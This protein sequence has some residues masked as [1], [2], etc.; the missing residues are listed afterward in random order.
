MSVVT[1]GNK[2]MMLELAPCCLLYLEKKQQ[3]NAYKCYMCLGILYITNISN[4]LLMCC[5][6]VARLVVEIGNIIGTNVFM[7]FK[8]IELKLN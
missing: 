8:L 1:E 7:E 6:K 3:Q 5:P 4:G 2:Q